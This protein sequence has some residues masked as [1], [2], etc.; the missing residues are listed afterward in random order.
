[1]PPEYGHLNRHYNFGKYLKRAGYNPVVFVG[2]NLHNSNV[3]M[4]QDDSLYKIYEDC[5]YPYVFV[6]TCAYDRSRIKRVYAMFEFYRNICKVTK[7][8]DRP[9]VIL[10]SSA[11]PLA[12]MAAI[13]L[14]KKYHCKSVVEVRDLWPESFVAY[15]IIKKSNPLLKLLYAGEKWIY[16]KA[17]S[18]VFT[19][20]GA[21]DYIVNRGWDME[22]GGPIDLNKICYINNGVDLEVFDYN[23]EHIIIDDKDLLDK[24]S[25]KVVYTG[26]IRLVNKM[27]ILLDVAKILKKSGVKFL[28]WGD[29]DQLET[30]K[31]RIADENIDNVCFKGRVDKKYVPYITTQCQLNIIFGENM[32][33]FQYGGSMNKMFDYF[34]SGKPTL[35]TFKVGYSLIDKYKAG[36]ELSG[37]STEKIAETI[38]YFK[39]LNDMAYHEYCMNA[40]RAAED[41]SFKNLTASLIDVLK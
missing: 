12:P 36:A 8:F 3:Q 22:S 14:A 19:M 10:G 25:F 1:M 35:L 32:P 31:A 41:Y 33:L 11:H 30:L 39:N 16:K 38:L 4:I 2:S 21:K 24:E 40:R 34:A 15:K 29:G 27:G 18:L 20:K 7:E 13:K 37:S 6:K 28:V 5:D 9:D 26:S 23:K 17:D